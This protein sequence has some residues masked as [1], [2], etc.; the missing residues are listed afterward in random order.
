M[1]IVTPVSGLT[2]CLLSSG[3]ALAA[4]IS[5]TPAS[6]LQKLLD[7]SQAG[8][9]LVLEPGRYIGNFCIT[10]PV[11]LSGKPGVTVDGGGTGDALR[12]SAAGVTIRNLNIENWGDDLTEQNAGIYGQEGA[13]NIVVENNTLQGDGFGVYLERIDGGLIAG[14]RVKGNSDLRSA[15][16][17]NGIHLALV[18]NVEVRDNQVSRT[19]DG[20]YIISSQDNRLVNNQMYNLRFG[21]HYMYSHSNEVSG[22]IARGNRVGLALMSSRNLKIFN[23]T[24]EQNDDYGILMNFITYSDIRDNRVRNIRALYQDDSEDSIEGAEGKALFVYNSAFN[25][26]R[27]NSFAFSDLGIH[28]TAGSEGNK[29]YENAVINNRTQVKYVVNDPQEWS[30]SADN[31]PARG[32]YWS[33]YLGWDLDGDGLGDTVYEPNDSMDRLLWKY[34]SSRLLINSPAIVVL[35]WVQELF[36]VLK[37]SGVKDSFPLMD[38]P[39]GTLPDKQQAGERIM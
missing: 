30:G 31:G 39:T 16:R 27:G 9:I 13:D 11:I 7:N 37:S 36:P 33:D 38:D 35:R 21:V 20:L 2:A 17:G 10:V 28:L 18:K 26:I 34:P 12:I 5:V 25:T 8:N 15:D 23:N 4:E 24:S 22:N 6:D 29:V 1:K 14:N 32:N 3:M 19:R